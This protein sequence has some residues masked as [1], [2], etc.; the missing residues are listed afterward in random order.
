MESAVM[1]APGARSAGR[2]RPT[3]EVRNLRVEFATRR[4]TLVAVNDVS[5]AIGEGEVLGVVGE[6]GA[7]KSLTGAAVIGLLEPPGRIAAGEV[8]LDGERIDHLPYERLRRLVPGL[9]H[10]WTSAACIVLGSPARHSVPC[11]VSPSSHCA[12]RARSAS[13]RGMSSPVGRPMLANR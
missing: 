13:R 1:P 10:A 8:L 12:T 6:S 7:G 5:F 9:A 2:N 4:G 3:L 11:R